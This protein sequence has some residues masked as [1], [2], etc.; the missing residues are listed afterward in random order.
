MGFALRD[1]KPVRP[2]TERGPRAR[3]LGREIMRLL[4]FKL[5]ALIVLFTL[6]FSP[7]RRPQIEAGGFA[8]RLLGGPRKTIEGLRERIEG[9][10]EGIGDKGET[11]GHE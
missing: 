1:E 7:A 4:L 2:T 3:A 9:P 10:R 6:F 5:V 11:G 8:E